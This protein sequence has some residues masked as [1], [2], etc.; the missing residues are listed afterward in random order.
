MV[1]TSTSR[2]PAAPRISGIAERAADL[3]QLAARDDHLAA[4]REGGEGEHQRGRVVVDRERR[5]GAGERG[6]QP[7]DARPAV[8]AAAG[9]EIE[10]EVAAGGDQPGEPAG[11][12][13]RQ[14]R[15]AEVGVQED[16]GGV[17]HPDERPAEV[18]GERALDLGGQAGERRV[19]LR[20][21]P[22]L[23]RPG[24]RRR[25]AVA[26][27]VERGARLD[28]QPLAPVRCFETSPD[29]L[30][31]QAVHRGQPAARVLRGSDAHGMV[32]ILGEPLR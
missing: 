19:E 6:D 14:R 16:A 15:A 5:L 25:Q 13:G 2:A 31:E 10:L 27:R 11:D 8:A 32:F 30:G 7:R 23:I 20:R 21:H 17:E 29:G 18:V 26:Q 24:R 1:P 9:R 3:D 4:G 22:V 28:D 12:L